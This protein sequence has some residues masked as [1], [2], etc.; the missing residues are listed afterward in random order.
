MKRNEVWRIVDKAKQTRRIQQEKVPQDCKT[1]SRRFDSDRR[2]HTDLIS[3]IA[4]R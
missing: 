2:L 1:F 3:L 4:K